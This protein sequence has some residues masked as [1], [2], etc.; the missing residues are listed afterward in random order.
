MLSTGKGAMLFVHV[1][2]FA[3]L[4]ERMI[5]S[6][7]IMMQLIFR[8]KSNKPPYVGDRSGLVRVLTYALVLGE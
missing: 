2:S 3:A 1:L 8:A 6:L 4:V 7:E 5:F